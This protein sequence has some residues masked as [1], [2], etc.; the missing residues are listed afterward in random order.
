MRTSKMEVSIKNFKHNIK[1]IQDYVGK[2]ELMPVIKANAYGTYLNTRIDIL[3]MFNIVAVA[4]LDEAGYL[5]SIG[6][7]KDIFILNQPAISDLEE[8]YDINPVIG[9]S[10]LE[11]LH[12]V[13]HKLRV[14]LEIETGMN[15]TGIKEDELQEFINEV[16]KNNNIIVEGV[17]THLS[18]ADE[19][20]EYT[21][22][23]IE[24]FKRCVDIVKK[25]FDIKYIHCEASNGILNYNV[26]FTNLVRPG[27]IMYGYE[28]YPGVYKKID[29]KPT[30][31]LST[32]I[33][34]LKDVNKGDSI[35]YSRKYKAYDDSKIATIPIGYADG[36]R[37]DLTNKGYVVINGKRAPLVG[38]ICMD[39]CMVDVTEIPNVKVGD[40]VYIFDNDLITLDYIA[41]TCLTIPYE[42]LCNISYR[43][44]R[45]FIDE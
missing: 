24:T 34:F 5:R 25:E 2:K 39:S 4:I 27:I 8:I 7:E 45:K 29:I 20:K 35:S 9:L 28:S 21:T 43:I 41:E 16:K 30:C 22:M 36:F 26:D 11:F 42:I 32:E 19:D 44:P 40:K 15:R 6:Y 33:T 23:Q 14:H 13:K 3:N 31:K 18:S 1:V 17:Y 10:S 12:N 38:A 37:R